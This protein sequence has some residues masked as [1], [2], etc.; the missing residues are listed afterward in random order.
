MVWA[1]RLGAGGVLG[2]LA[3]GVL[4]GFCRSAS[5]IEGTVDGELPRE[6]QARLFGCRLCPDALVP[7]L[8]EVQNELSFG[9]QRLADVPDGFALVGSLSPG[10]RALFQGRSGVRAVRR[11]LP[12]LFLAVLRS[13]LPCKAAYRLSVQLGDRFWDVFSVRRL[14]SCSELYRFRLRLRLCFEVLRRFDRRCMSCRTLVPA[15]VSD[16][17]PGFVGWINRRPV[18]LAPGI[19]NI[20]IASLQSLLLLTGSVRTC[21]TPHHIR[22]G[23]WRTGHWVLGP[24][25]VRVPGLSV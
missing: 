10:R 24:F 4:G 11:G 7:G 19:I 25:H 3:V 8:P 12:R 13:D 5:G 22:V 9:R 20:P 17:D 6:R 18:V 15:C 23:P 14:F 16:V 1:L 21:T 2:G